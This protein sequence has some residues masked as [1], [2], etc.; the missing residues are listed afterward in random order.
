VKP[1]PGHLDSH[2][3]LDA[4]TDYRVMR[5]NDG[6]GAREKSRVTIRSERSPAR[7]TA[8]FLADRARSRKR[9]RVCIAAGLFVTGSASTLAVPSFFLTTFTHILS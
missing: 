7:W 9:D 8:V 6:L 5:A 1:T 3:A 2:L 4:S